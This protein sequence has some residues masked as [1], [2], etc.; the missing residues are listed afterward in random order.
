MFESLLFCKR[1]PFA[2]H[3]T[4]GVSRIKSGKNWRIRGVF[5]M[6]ENIRTGNYSRKEV[7]QT[8]LAGF[9]T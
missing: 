6:R 8:I 5:S 9:G 7:K 3:T 4:Q 1:E 2:P